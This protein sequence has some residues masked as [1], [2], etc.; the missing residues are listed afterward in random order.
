MR[1]PVSPAA[2]SY[3]TPKQA[4]RHLGVSTSLLAKLRCCVEGGGPA[5]A[6]LGH[7][8]RYR[9][10]ELDRWAREH[11]RNAVHPVAV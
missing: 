8:V 1:F 4:A 10:D 6:K 9:R 2:P 5:Y 11:E 3:L 7:A